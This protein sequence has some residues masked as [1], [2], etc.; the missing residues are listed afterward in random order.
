MGLV[1]E[2]YVTKIIAS[3]E[4]GHWAPLQRFVQFAAN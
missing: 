3:I 1:K 4:N 2:R